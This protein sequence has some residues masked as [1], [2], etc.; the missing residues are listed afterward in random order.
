MKLTKKQ[1]LILGGVFLGSI[2]IAYLLKPFKAS[3]NWFDPNTKWFKDEASRKKVEQLH[4]L[5]KQK[6]AEFLTRLE[7]DMGLSALV[8]SGLR[9]IAEQEAQY[10][11]NPNNAKPGYSHHNYGF[12]FDINVKDKNGNIVLSKSTS[13]DKWKKSGVPALAEKVG[14]V[15]KGDFGNYHDPVHFYFSPGMSTTELYALYKDGKVD[16]QGYVIV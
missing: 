9:T 10:K 15:W 5:A 3:K 12:A 14:L 11:V 7:T 2:L 8:T 6:F 4:P 16:K 1:Y 13:T